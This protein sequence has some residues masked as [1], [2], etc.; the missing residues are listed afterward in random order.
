M[1]NDCLWALS[2]IVTGVSIIVLAGSRVLGIALPDAVVRIFGILG[3]VSL[4]VL[5]FTT[6]KKTRKD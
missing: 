6:I 3:L 5:V 2:L 1:K 4:L